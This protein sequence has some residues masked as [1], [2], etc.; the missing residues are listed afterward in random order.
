[1]NRLII[2]LVIQLIGV[3]TIRG[4]YAIIPKPTQ[5][6][7][8]AGELKVSKHVRIHLFDD[9][10]KSE[11]HYLTQAL[12]SRSYTVDKNAVYKPKKHK[13]FVISL[14]KTSVENADEAYEIQVNEDGI[15]ISA[16]KPVGKSCVYSLCNF[17]DYIKSAQ[18]SR[19]SLLHS[20]KGG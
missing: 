6:T 9:H 15:S 18:S 13:D 4:Q 10:F 8:G 7:Y 2:L 16:N 14:K 11:A 1:M 12:E 19:L 20:L 17:W 3:L 5:L